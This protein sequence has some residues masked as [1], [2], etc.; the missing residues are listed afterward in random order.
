[1]SLKDKIWVAVFCVIPAVILTAMNDYF[2]V[3]SSKKAMIGSLLF[4]IGVLLGY[5]IWR[6]VRYSAVNH[7][8]AAA[9]VMSLALIFTSVTI[10]N[11]M[12]NR[13]HT[14]E[15]C[16]YKAVKGTEENCSLCGSEVWE[17]L[18]RA[19]LQTGD[20]N[21]WL[22]EEQLFMFMLDSVNQP[23]SFYLTDNEDGYE[24]DLE[25]QP[26]ISEQDLKNELG[27]KSHLKK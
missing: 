24:K 27:K 18:D 16:G 13:L 21:E 10:S 9:T 22:K 23:I 25:W 12:S 20:K 26:I 19:A 14:C 15:V 6:I 3:N 2:D 7:K 11:A 17:K 1:M 4:V 8:I 5:S